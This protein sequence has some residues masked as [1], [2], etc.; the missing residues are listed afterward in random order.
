MSADTFPN[1]LL[2]KN[3]RRMMKVHAPVEVES[4]ARFATRDGEFANL[5]FHTPEQY[6]AIIEWL[7]EPTDN[8]RVLL[9]YAGE[10]KTRVGVKLAV[11]S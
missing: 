5:V 11:Q 3:L 2:A 7:T 9:E 8:F 4:V 1:Q 6:D 10:T